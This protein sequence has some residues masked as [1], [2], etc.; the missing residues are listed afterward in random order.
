MK[1]NKY[2][3]SYISKISGKKKLYILVML[4]VQVLVGVTGV[5]Y[6][7]VM[8]SV[9]DEAVSK[10][11]EGFI[12]SILIFSGLVVFQIILCAIGRFMEEYAKSSYE[13]AFKERLFSVLLKGDYLE[14]SKV[15]SGEWMN[16]L[17]SD[18]VVVANG[19]TSI[20]PGVA[21]MLV[22]L[23]CAIIMILLIEPL[24]AYILVPGGLLLIVLT[25]GFRKVLKKLH[26]RMQEADGEVRTYMQEHL[27]SLMVVKAFA[28][29]ED[30]VHCASERMRLHKKARM[31]K[32]HFSNVCNIGFGGVMNGAYAV[33]LAYCGYRLLQGSMSYG[34]LMA[35][36]QLISQIQS[37]FANIT[38]YLPQY[39]AMIASAERLME[40][41]KYLDEN[42]DDIYG[43]SHIKEF[44]ENEFESICVNNVSFSYEEDNPVLENV[45]MKIDKGEF[46]A[47][48]GES[49]CGKSTFIKLLIG[50]YRPDK[51]KIMLG[52]NEFERKY[53]K[54]YA[55]VP[56][57]NHLMSGT[58][59]DIVS[60]AKNEDNDDEQIWKSLDI[61]CADFVRKLPDGLDTMLGEK[62][63][64]LS[65]GQMQRIAIA[66]AVYSGCPLLI[67]DEATSALDCDT[68]NELLGN[69]KSMTDKTVFII[70][71]RLAVLDVCDRHVEW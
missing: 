2:A 45:S 70:T 66:R 11:K 19:L 18:T 7:L 4:L 43:I 10:K 22:R 36:L 47:F 8:R 50:L 23:L 57:G 25:Y 3:L 52:N 35:L 40:A 58:I 28:V 26:K 6:A 24:F 37:P 33:G 56:Q 71:H 29:E 54:L 30:T 49:G 46:I 64:G 39:Y 38:G 20:I 67:L 62:G 51:G 59:R 21:G 34:T 12:F 13:N 41:E 17:T 32:N 27:G 63:L 61:A 42:T 15:H 1:N 65:E 16:R 14:I 53:R 69:L 31:K 9:I 5:S 44:Y 55:Y 60:L 48:T 68:E